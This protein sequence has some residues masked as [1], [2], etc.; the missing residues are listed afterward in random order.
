[1]ITSRIRSAVAAAI[2]ACSA[3]GAGEMSLPAGGAR[4]KAD[5]GA[6]GAAASYANPVVPFDCPDPGILAAGGSEP[7][8]Y[9]VC[10]GGRFTIRRSAD[11]VTWETTDAAIL[12][13]GKASWSANGRR[14]WAPELHRVGPRTVAYFTA[15]SAEDRL[16]IGVASADDPLG[17]YE[18]AA[19]PLV[20]D[21]RGVIDATYFRDGDGRHYLFYKIDGNAQGGATPIYAR[22]LAAD[23]LAFKA[24]SRAVEVLSNDP[25][26]W[27]GGVVEAPWVVKRGGRYYIF[28]SGNVYDQRYRTGVA[29]A[30]SVLGP[31]AKRGAPLLA[32]DADWVGPG[33][34][35]VVTVGQ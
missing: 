8:Y 34:G 19:A 29:R 28:Y 3:C 15:A 20:E 13:E 11:L 33:H 23:G 18:V 14:N 6:G 12:P 32:N 35:S 25:A 24:G 30:E 17:P 10:T 7:R 26:S 22:E 4:G 31:Y 5:E 21:P 27:E 9:M 16:A 1:M 2:V